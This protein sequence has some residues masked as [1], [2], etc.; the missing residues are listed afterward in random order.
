MIGDRAY[1]VA[2]ATEDDRRRQYRQITD[3]RRFDLLGGHYPQFD[4]Q[5]NSRLDTGKDE[6]ST[7]PSPLLT[8]AIL[9]ASALPTPRC[10]R[11]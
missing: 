1:A 6:G 9:Y 10:Q 7:E 11:A 8:R 3:M 2:H 4:R 5:Q